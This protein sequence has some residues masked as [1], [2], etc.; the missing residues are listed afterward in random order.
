M[1]YFLN[2]TPLETNLTS[3]LTGYQNSDS[4]SGASLSAVVG[5]SIANILAIF[6]G[7]FGNSLV[8]VSVII[9]RGMRSTTNIFIASLAGAD[10]I[11]T[12]TCM[13]LFFVYNVLTWP[14][15][16][17]GK[18]GCRILSFLVHMSVMA[19][20]LSLLAIS[21]D[22]FVSV[23]FP[24]KRFIT[25]PR[26]KK[27]VGV[28]WFVSPFLLLPSLFHHDVVSK[29]IKAAK[30]E[31]SWRSSKALHSY[32]MYRISCYFLFLLQISVLYFLIG[33]R[34]YTRQQP[35]EQTSQSKAKDLLSKRKIIKMLFL[36]VALFALC[37]L[38]YMINKLLNI[39]PPSP[40]YYAP[41]LFVFVGNFLGLLN[42]VAN[43]I[44]Y[45]VLNK[46][47]RKAFKNALRCN[48]NYELEERRRT[49]SVV[50]KQ[51]QRRQSE[52]LTLD[53]VHRNSL[54]ISDNQVV[55]YGRVVTGQTRAEIKCLS[56][57]SI[58]REAILELSK[59]PTCSQSQGFSGRNPEKR[60]VSF[61]GELL[62]SMETKDPEALTSENGSFNLMNGTGHC[63]N[64]AEQARQ[65]C[66]TDLSN[67]SP[68]QEKGHVNVSFE[69]DSDRI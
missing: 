23:F 52:S 2:S 51:A 6:F 68:V 54:S 47:F 69:L 9:N 31:E 63:P 14:V 28:I 61:G 46:N 19:S 29:E 57:T 12:S 66:G 43:P 8:I 38:P 3:N 36:V 26:A 56:F 58:E 33:R 65:R 50:S 39:F 1:N 64:R 59:F 42:S 24:L 25:P 30:C 55:S 4:N 22:R 60:R 41:D 37:W 49:A 11:V 62:S 34:L 67:L 40:G 53:R 17:Y 21:Y 15:W 18:T 44:V 20:A 16:P 45:A 27:I 35:G 10:V 5:L 48:C 32:Q 13:P 7:T